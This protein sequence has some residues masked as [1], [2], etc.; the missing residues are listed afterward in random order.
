M[1]TKLQAIIRV[2][3]DIFTRN[4]SV[5]RERRVLLCCMFIFSIAN[6]Y[7]LCS[8]IQ[9]TSGPIGGRFTH[10]AIIT[11]SWSQ[12]ST[13]PH[14]VLAIDI[15]GHLW[16]WGRNDYGQIDGKF[17]PNVYKPVLIDSSKKWISIAAGGLH[18]LGVDKEGNLYSWGNGERG[19]LGHRDNAHKS[20]FTKVDSV[21]I[22]WGYHIG[23]S[24]SNFLKVSA[25]YYHSM[26]LTNYTMGVGQIYGFGDNGSH[27]A[28]GVDFHI[29]ITIPMQIEYFPG[30]FI[31]VSCG[32]SNTFAIKKDKTLWAWGLNDKGQFGNDSTK[33]FNKKPRQIGND[34]NWLQI[35]A[36]VNH[37]LALKQDS[38]LWGWGQNTYYQLGDGG[39]AD[40][41]KPKKLHTKKWKS[42]SAGNYFSLAIDSK[43]SLFSWGANHKGQLG[44]GNTFYYNSPRY[45]DGES[46]I[47]S[48]GYDYSVI[49][50]KDNHVYSFGDNS[51]GK[52]AMGENKSSD[53]VWVKIQT[54]N[55]VIWA[56]NES[57]DDKVY[58]S[59]NKGNTWNWE[60]IN[61]G[62]ESSGP[63][64]TSVL[65]FFKGDI[66][67]DGGPWRSSDL[68]SSWY[69]GADQETKFKAILGIL[70]S[71]YAST[72]VQRKNYKD[73]YI[74]NNRVWW[75][76]KT[77][78]STYFSLGGIV[79]IRNF[80]NTGFYGDYVY[81]ANEP[82]YATN[83]SNIYFASYSNVYD[84]TATL[85]GSVTGKVNGFGLKKDTLLV[86]GKNGLFKGI[87][88][89]K[90][91]L[92]SS[93]IYNFN[94]IDF[95]DNFGAMVS[96]GKG[97]YTFNEHLNYQQIPIKMQY[98][99]DFTSIGK[100]L[101]VSTIGG[102]IY[103]TTNYGDSWQETS[104]G[105]TETE[106]FNIE[107]TS[108]DVYAT[109]D[110]NYYRLSSNKWFKQEGFDLDTISVIGSSRNSF[111]VKNVINTPDNTIIVVEVT[112]RQGTI[113]DHY[114]RIVIKNKGQKAYELN[115]VPTELFNSRTFSISLQNKNLIIAT[116]QGL[117]KGENY[118]ETWYRI[119]TPKLFSE[120]IVKDELLYGRLP[121]NSFSKSIDSLIYVSKNS[122]ITW[123][124]F[125]KGLPTKSTYKG[126]SKMYVSGG[127]IYAIV[128]NKLWYSSAENP[129][130]KKFDESGS[131][132][133][134][135]V[136]F[137]SV[138][139]FDGKLFLGTEAHSVWKAQLSPVLISPTDSSN[140]VSLSNIEFTWSFSEGIQL[141]EYQLS[142]DIN[143]TNIVH[144]R[145]FTG[146]T[147]VLNKT[148]DY[149]SQ[150]FWRVRLKNSEGIWSPW[151]GVNVFATEFPTMF[152]RLSPA[153]N[154]INRTMIQPFYFFETNQ[155]RKWGYQLQTADD[156]Q[157]RQNVKT[158]YY[159][160]VFFFHTFDKNKN[161]YYR[162]RQFDTTIGFGGKWYPESKYHLLA[163]APT[164]IDF[165][166]YRDVFS[167]GN[168]LGI[169]WQ[170][171]HYNKFN[172]SQFPGLEGTPKSWYPSYH[173][174][175]AAFGWQHFVRECCCIRRY[176]LFGPKKCQVVENY[177]TMTKWRQALSIWGYTWGGSCSGFSF[178]SIERWLKNQKPYSYA[179]DFSDELQRKINQQQQ[180]QL[181]KTYYSATYKRSA[182]GT[183][184]F[185][186]S[187]FNANNKSMLPVLSLYTGNSG[188]AV[189]PY[190]ITSGSQFDSIWVYD[191]WYHFV[192][193][194]GNIS[195]TNKYIVVNRSNGLWT[196]PNGFG[197]G[198]WHSTIMDLTPVTSFVFST[199]VLQPKNNNEKT[200]MNKSR[201]EF[202]LSAMD[203]VPT[204]TV[205]VNNPDGILIKDSKGKEYLLDK[206]PSL[207]S[208]NIAVIRSF[209]GLQAKS[210]VN[211]VGAHIFADKDKSDYIIEKI[212]TNSNDTSTVNIFGLGYDSEISWKGDNNAKVSLTI[213]DMNHGIKI[214]SEKK[215]EVLDF[216]VVKYD[217]ILDYQKS[218]KLNG[219]SLD[220]NEEFFAGF[221]PDS[222]EFRISNNGQEKQYD[223]VVDLGIEIPLKNVEFGSKDVHIYRLDGLGEED[224]TKLTITVDRR[225]SGKDDTV[226]V[227]TSVVEEHNTT[228]EWYNKKRIGNLG[229]NIHP[230][231][232]KDDLT[233]SLNLANS[234]DITIQIIDPEGRQVKQ[235]VK[236]YRHTGEYTISTDVRELAQ[237]LYYLMVSTPS[238]SISE[239]FIII[240]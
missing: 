65:K 191:N 228:I 160:T 226:I 157:F 165:S 64:Y 175:Y 108:N 198:A 45:I 143:F 111:K 214:K 25:G 5:T 94:G 73:L 28:V 152:V 51:I 117:Y 53:S 224:T 109:T 235:L 219:T 194:I 181:S 50:K 163:V 232:V 21:A 147:F 79:A 70:D 89:F 240:K 35:S 161:Y 173:D 11:K 105:L 69:H 177:N 75:E 207:D 113:V 195:S 85:R 84:A 227:Y 66:Y 29:P 201:G 217:Q 145:E 215:N 168:Y 27:G 76:G 132:I 225:S 93:K 119:S 34:K 22:N 103:E 49:V 237:G 188:H 110:K 164:Q 120:V 43:D 238:Q 189:V 171:A 210:D 81:L 200:L 172:Y 92:D 135:D 18:S 216:T 4:I 16:G 31:D 106:V 3:N 95:K 6:S 33:I 144:Q 115:N 40:Q 59:R 24:Q 221:S 13:G 140:N 154:P 123:E 86:V 206:T 180:Y 121:E 46:K 149:A 30:E 170:P 102:G 239:N 12:I 98:V 192:P 134:E 122:G 44:T 87:W 63:S 72:L 124:L 23:V 38:T 90:S 131:N 61:K 91:V 231:P 88:N 57:Y 130:W 193:D 118:G 58:V 229:V 139:E 187:I 97:I 183:V 14:H 36:G 116:S 101:Y 166:P 2:L 159:D 52:A 209:G 156:I 197:D 222:K 178:H 104:D 83:K 174:F 233:F 220:N 236:G 42:I 230:N 218:I 32:N 62:H 153:S 179:L 41:L 74:E 150:Y 146:T 184:E 151:S 8:Q 141:Y 107:S 20:S 112:K 127:A 77:G 176:L 162:M 133:D 205:F 9:Q 7:P 99:S 186:R 78:A 1:K 211:V 48:A 204:T 37:T 15:E 47:I 10:V 142:K 199:P 234:M 54:E 190:M 128:E 125:G 126:C 26:V 203:S 39:A 136:R 182:Q 129:N 17:P 167:S 82:N 67:V 80:E 196:F 55:D 158:Y 213:S 60:K 208:S 71:W 202:L 185:L 169:M 114:T 212:N 96:K 19:Q 100:T 223:I 138:F 155:I 68:G 148:L 137:T 56:L